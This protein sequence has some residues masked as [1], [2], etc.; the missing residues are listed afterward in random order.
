[1]PDQPWAKIGVDLFT[2]RGQNYLISVNYSSSFWEIDPLDN[3][4][5]GSVKEVKVAVGRYGIQEIRVSDN[6]SQFTS[7]EFREFSHQWNFVPCNEFSNL[8]AKQWKG[9]SRC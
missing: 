3:T 1:M 6:G 8:S 4:T 9:R 2:Y 7:T 5:L